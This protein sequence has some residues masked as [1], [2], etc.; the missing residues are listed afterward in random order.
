MELFIQELRKQ[1]LNGNLS[2]QIEVFKRAYLHDV[3]QQPQG[4]LQLF[5]SSL[6]LENS[7]LLF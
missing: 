1:N 3:L 2:R 6:G 7:N 5:P 4:P